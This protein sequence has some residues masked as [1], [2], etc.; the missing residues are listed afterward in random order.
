[1]ERV[2]EKVVNNG[3]H[4]ATRI[5]SNYI[6]WWETCSTPYL[7]QWCP[8][9]YFRG[10]LL[11]LDGMQAIVLM[12]TTSIVM[13]SSAKPIQ[14]CNGFVNGSSRY[15]VHDYFNDCNIKDQSSNELLVSVIRTLLYASLFD[16]KSGGDICVFKVTKK[17]FN[18]INNLF[19][20]RFVLITMP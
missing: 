11:W 12:Y 10:V 8:Q 4:S 9:Y 15:K 20:K 19:W 3:I 6:G 5:A 14:C 7:F 2:S 1:M 17:K 13:E 16:R 18:V